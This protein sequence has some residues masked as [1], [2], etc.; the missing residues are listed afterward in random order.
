MRGIEAIGDQWIS[1]WPQMFSVHI[2][3]AGWG[4]S[5]LLGLDKRPRNKGPGDM[6]KMHIIKPP[7]GSCW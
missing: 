3:Q 6:Q 2:P 4:R 5:S 1:C 7:A